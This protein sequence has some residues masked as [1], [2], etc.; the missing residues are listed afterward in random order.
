MVKNPPLN[1]GDVGLIPGWG[2]KVPRAARQLS[3]R[4]AI[5][6]LGAATTEPTRSGA[7]VQ[8]LLGPRTTT[9]EKP[10]R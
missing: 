3:P 2:T 4:A 8:P 6:E 9:R 5:R 1:A 7:G 10:S